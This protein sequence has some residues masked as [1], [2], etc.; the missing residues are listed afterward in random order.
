MPMPTAAEPLI[1][2][3]LEA[4]VA[5]RSLDL[6]ERAPLRLPPSRTGGTYAGCL[7]LLRDGRSPI[8]WLAEAASPDGSVSF[9]LA[10]LLDHRPAEAVKARGSL[11]GDPPQAESDLSVV[12]STCANG[13]GVLACVK[14]LLA[15]D[16]MPREIIVV[17]NRPSRSTVK[18]ELAERFP[19][20]SRI[21]YVEEHRRGLSSARNAGLALVQ[22]KHVAFTDD[23]VR[24]DSGWTA[25]IAEAFG[26]P[27]APDCVTGLIAPFELET[28]A[29]LLVEKFAGYGKGMQ[30]RL[31][32][33][34]A[35]PPDEPLFPYA[36]GHYASGANIAFHTSFLRKL[37]GFAVALGAGTKARGG[38]DLDICIRLFRAGG[39]L[40]YVP[41]AIVWHR[42]RDSEA[43]L[44]RG[45]FDMGV[46]V[47]AVLGKHILTG[48]DRWNILKRAPRAVG[49]F[50]DPG[51]RKN[52]GR[53]P[54]FPRRLSLVEWSG[55]AYGPL[56]YLLSRN[57]L[58]RKAR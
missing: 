38:E 51:S 56:A 31:Y 7:V 6:G 16:V 35:A 39:T 26:G 23:D 47:G 3:G 29:Q 49:Y 32:S 1:M 50:L 13:P 4:P 20:D 48:S 2:A 34:E 8:G 54:D 37:G 57:D 53:G 5:V 46:A 45:A 9:D 17:E 41:G 12:V 14:S 11:R 27:G 25:A 24:A 10:G 19:E 18:T 42:H 36:A 30:S 55:L 15:G 33:L 28:P 58:P 44:Q 52:S 43:Q 21:R 40:A 22:G